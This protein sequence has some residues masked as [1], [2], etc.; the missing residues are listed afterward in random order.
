MKNATNQFTNE[1]RAVIRRY[2]D[3]SD[4]RYIEIFGV[5]ELLKLEAWDRWCKQDEEK[6]ND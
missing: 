6:D 5:L 4:L 2:T 1:M 3:E